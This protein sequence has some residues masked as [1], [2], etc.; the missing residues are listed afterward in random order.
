M[1]KKISSKAFSLQAKI[2]LIFILANILVFIVNLILMIGV[3]S[4]ANKLDAVYRE[5][6]HLNELS[7]SITKV[8]ESMTDYLNTKTSD[9]LGEYY[10]NEQNYLQLVSDLDIKVTGRYYDRMIRN[11][12]YMS[13]EYLDT[14]AQVIEAKR[15]RN[16]E[17]YSDRHEEASE[18]YS[19]INTYIY[20]LNNELFK[21]NSESYS[22][23][24]DAFRLFEVVSMIVLF[25]AIIGN[26]LI[27][28]GLTG[29]IIEPLK[30]LS[31]SADDVAKGN[32]DI[33]LLEITSRDE[34]GVVTNA[35]N[36]MVISIR[37]YIEQIK[38]S[39]EVERAL[40]EKELLIESNLKDAQLKYLQAQINPHFLFNTLNAGAQLAM[41]EEADKTYD[42]IQNMADF[43]RYNVR[44]G[45]ETVT[46]QEEIESID[47]YIYILNVRF[48]GEI[49]YEKDIDP[50]LLDVQ[51]PCMILQP[52]VENC[53]NHGIKEME[54]KGKITIRVYTTDGLVCICI[55]D[56]GIGMS[57]DTIERIMT[58]AL[59]QKEKK[60]SSNGIAIENVINRLQ[61][62][63]ERDDVLLIESAGEGMGT[64]VTIFI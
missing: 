62:Y 37:A 40:K 9:S 58:G 41:M 3:N 46:I 38:D 42:Y 15:G 39:M 29:T 7:S 63:L 16:V 49:H 47:H 2:S 54:G 21:N 14:T 5:N 24:S 28:V 25:L 64:Q 43:F 60:S 57:A 33:E 1:K 6:L 45:N 55:A 19:Y 48:A 10:R 34:V 20:S 36:K 12:K 11:I 4:M 27:I 56:N 51:I 61:L 35:F 13:V 8:Q 18:L 52:L 50:T 31:K 53:V 23:L 32:L 59:K 17:K 26:A 30:K 44:K 22:T